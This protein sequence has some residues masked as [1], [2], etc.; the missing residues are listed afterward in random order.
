M[1][2]SDSIERETL[3]DAPPAVVWNVITDPAQI[4]QWFCDGAELEARPGGDGAFRWGDYTADLRVVQVEQPRLFAF[5]WLHPQGEE[6]RPGNSTL[7]EFTLT[8]EGDGT[9]L[10]VVE[11]GLTATD[12]SDERKAEFFESHTDGWQR[13]VADLTA[14]ASRREVAAR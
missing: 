8:A 9:R 4:R 13:H 5:R 3:I 2:I 10:L 11:S 1:S 7:V 14:Y 12:W 6:P